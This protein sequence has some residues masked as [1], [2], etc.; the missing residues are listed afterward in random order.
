MMRR[1][2]TIAIVL[3]MLVSAFPVGAASAADAAAIS[4]TGSSDS[5]KL[6]DV[7]IPTDAKAHNEKDATQGN[8][9][10]TRAAW[11]QEL[12]KTFDMTVEEAHAPDNYFTDLTGEESYYRDILVAVQFGVVDIPAGEAFYPENAAT[13]EFAA[14]TLNSC[15]GYL[16]EPSDGYTFSESDT[17]TYPDA[18]QIA[19]NRGW[20]QLS[21]SDFLPDQA[22]T[23]AEE[24]TMLTDAA[25]TLESRVIDT[26]YRNTYTFQ[27]DV[28]EIPQG[29]DV[30]IVQ[31]TVTIKNCPK[32]LKAGDVFV[33]W[34]Q[35]VPCAYVASTVTVAGT[36]TTIAATAVSDGSAVTDADAQGILDTEFAQF[37]PD[38]GTEV[39]YVDEATGIEYTDAKEADRAIA[40]HQATRGTKKLKTLQ[41]KS[42]VDLGS[43]IS[44][45]VT[46]K[47]KDPVLE[48]KFSSKKKVASVI[49]TAEYEVSVEAKAELIDHAATK[50]LRL[51]FW[52][53]P[54]VGGIEVCMVYSLSGS[55]TG[56][57]TGTLCV[58]AEYQSGAGFSLPKTFKS[59]GFSFIVE[60][61][62]KSGLQ[63][64]VGIND[65]PCDLM[66]GQVYAE[67]GAKGSV[68]RTSYSDNAD[69]NV[70]VH[71]AMYVYL[72][73]G[74]KLAFK[75][76]NFKS[77]YS[78]EYKIWKDSN[79]PV[80]VVHHYEDGKE[81]CSCTR[82]QTY[83]DNGYYTVG[84]SNYWGSGW[85]GGSGGT[86]Y[87][88]NGNPIPV[89]E[90]SV[91][92]N[93]N[94]TI[95]KYH[96]TGAAVTIPETIDG[97]AVTAIGQKAFYDN[98]SL[99]T[100]SLPDSITSI[101]MYAF[102]NCT[103][104]S[105]INLP[106][107]LIHLG[108]N[109][110]K[111]CL[112]LKIVTIPKSLES[113]YG[114]TNYYYG[115]GPFSDSGIEI[116]Y[117]EAGATSVVPNL[118]DGA[119]KLVEVNLLDTM[120]SIGGYAFADCTALQSIQLPSFITSIGGYAFE[121][122]TGLDRIE[123][124]KS[125]KNLGQRVFCG[126]SEIKEVTIPKSLESAYGGTNYYYGGGPFSD[127]GIEIV[128][129]EAGATSVVPNLFDGANKLVEVNLLDTMTSI[130]GYAFADC[131][132]L[133]TISIPDSVTSIGNY[134]F[135]GCTSLKSFQ[136]PPNLET[137]G[138]AV[139]ENC[140]SLEA[141]VW[142]DT[143]PVILDNTFSG[144]SSLKSFNI[145]DCVNTIGSGAFYGCTSLSGVTGGKN[146]KRIF[147]EAFRNCTSLK[148]ITLTNALSDIG[149]SAFQGCVAL[150]AI[151]IPNSVS[152]IGAYVFDGCEALKDIKLGTGL[153]EIPKQAFSN[154]SVLESI[155]LPYRVE[156]IGDNAF[157]N[158]V[159]FNSVTIPRR[160]TSISTNAFSYPDRLTVYG[161]SGTYAETYAGQ[162]G[163]K[164]VAI[165]RPTTSVSLYQ[166]VLT[167][168][169]NT[170]TQLVATISPADF[171][172]EVAWKTSDQS[173][174]T[175][176]DA[177]VVKAV[178]VGECTVSVV[179]GNVR[180][181]CKISVVQPVTSISLN[182][183]TLSM[184]AGQTYQLTASVYPGNAANRNVEWSSS[185]TSIAAVDENGL[186]TA[187]KK[188]TAVITAKAK[189]G[190][191]VEKSCSVT[192]LNN[193][194]VCNTVEQL[195]SPHPYEINCSDIWQYSIPG[196]SQLKVTFSADTS[197]ES[198]SDYLYIFDGNDG[199][200]GKYTGTELAGKTILVP[201]N[202][203]KIK[204]V[205]DGTYCEY[206]FCVTR[207]TTSG[208]HE[209]D[210]TATVV[211]PTCTE[212]GYTEHICS[213][214]DSYR[215][216]YVPALGHDFAWVVD[217]EPTDT[218]AGEKH[219]ECNRC[220]E[221]RNE[222]TIIPPQGGQHTHSYDSVITAPTCTERGY[223]THTCSC[224][225]SY[226]DTYLDPLGHNW[227]ASTYVWAGDYSSI[228]ATHVCKRDA[229]HVET[230]NGLIS[231]SVTREATY[232]TEGE[233]VYTA[234]FVN[235]AFKTQSKA[236][237]TPKLERP[238]PIENPFTDVRNGQYYYDAVLWAV[239]NGVTTGTSATTFSPG[240]GCT[241]AQ[242]VTF[243]W[244]AAGQPAPAS[245]ANP[246]NDVKEGAYYYKAV[247]WAVEKGITNGTS[248]TTFGPDDTCTR[249]QIVTFLWRYE[250]QPTPTSTNNPFADVKPS[251]Y[252]GSAV[253]WAVERD[254]TN[255][256]S[257]TTFAPEDTCTRAQVVTF[258]YRDIV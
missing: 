67:I 189:D 93:G 215:D 151:E 13:R 182:K 223:T 6:H 114:G 115:G 211:A 33:V 131:T 52:G 190:S 234:T 148:S 162:I 150:T 40:A 248:D 30:E 74:A 25:A 191:G 228:T 258:L 205:S 249:A 55:I 117:F 101:N 46:A 90:Y 207:V 108:Q 188:G 2:I 62:F 226:V 121:N 18:I 181:T 28:I 186:V 63:I 9:I 8:D 66:S 113:A 44:A 145:P 140:S 152:S 135:Y 34:Y 14:Q 49:L 246:F 91:D 32:T 100:I 68:K 183:S 120:T 161:V 143:Y 75:V 78:R 43:G 54:G 180:A 133:Q 70:C 171:T 116:V 22:I 20:F 103:Q 167:M 206:G 7:T 218:E 73:C 79:S 60:A 138:T 124:P 163:A 149:T 220:H 237:V 176:S 1:I 175:V 247:L 37:V 156:K 122:C 134:A 4:T 233:I 86:G 254:I 17:V 193:L 137:M 92:D 110:F 203:V 164:F 80:R 72:E 199:Q 242:V 126:C 84:T 12:V 35:S 56:S 210:Y 16:H 23:A 123:L 208:Q 83:G 146:V 88:R 76:A 125:L 213:C 222:G 65:V 57:F 128:Y 170:T 229:S 219:E 136:I 130:G 192:V 48:Y 214:G 224:G 94:A 85:N 77:E 15:L 200:I 251:A 29:T 173:V 5:E 104:L 97:H 71:T 250:G 142:N 53:C 244:R 185:D 58:G 3:C 112:N 119:N 225:D 47:L 26:N 39:V 111:N 153:T 96:G 127:S 69:P 38:A 81:V 235:P 147:S 21:G 212:Q 95:T 217:R 157:L 165:S 178:G 107:S 27:K 256:T 238:Q 160:T 236:V 51:G 201:G 172:D 61:S 243:L 31:N 132:S 174:A 202:T 11:I 159:K 231:S 253:L 141:V 209:H 255:G 144:C 197:V 187:L 24:S 241:R 184:D 239:E 216:S 99:Q 82:G 42:T 195:Q 204:L 198:G 41:L 177:G 10:I 106:K 169:R 89:F 230:E 194:T 45:S 109:V 221:K 64:N 154:C 227:A 168:N 59:K 196:A 36:T 179:A 232:D 87:D 139:F 240:E 129:F 155:T 252:F 166:T 50:K 102:G 118:F 19:I 158:D 245:S 98:V 105:T 257:A